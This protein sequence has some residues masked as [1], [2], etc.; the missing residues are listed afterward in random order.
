PPRVHP[1]TPAATGRR[2]FSPDP[3]RPHTPR[4]PP[5]ESRGGPP[6]GAKTPPYRLSIRS[7][8]M[9]AAAPGALTRQPHSHVPGRMPSRL[10]SQEVSQHLFRASALLGVFLFEKR[11][12][13]AAKSQPEQSFFQSIKPL[14]PLRVHPLQPKRD[15]ALDR[16]R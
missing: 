8:R 7:K 16:S 9:A 13:C 2:V 11:A 10:A 14:S 1:P 12:G 5:W 3:W 15:V 6:G 4:P